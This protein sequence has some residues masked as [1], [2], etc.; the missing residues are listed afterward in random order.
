MKTPI[1]S[2]ITNTFID[3]VDK[4]MTDEKL[5]SII[6]K[7][8]NNVSFTES[9]YG[10]KESTYDKVFEARNIVSTNGEQMQGFVPVTCSNKELA[11]DFLRF[12]VSKKGQSVYAQ[13]MQGL[14]MGYGYNPFDDEEV[15]MSEFVKSV[16][17]CFENSNSI[18]VYRDISEL[19]SYRG[20]L[21]AFT[22]NN[23][24]YTQAIFT[25]SSA[26]A[27]Y[28][29]TYNTLKNQWSKYLADSNLN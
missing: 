7:I 4:Q 2:S 27:V 22:T 28:N 20:G 18:Y 9:E 11:A 26:L 17:D 15:E 5:S 6:E 1:L 12:M 13:E 3:S 16:H 23:N 10:C 24:L 29:D 14:H 8:D 25:G 19:L 21:A